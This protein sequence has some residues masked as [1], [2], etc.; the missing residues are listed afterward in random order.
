M[1]QPQEVLGVKIVVGLK[2]ASTLWAGASPTRWLVLRPEK[3]STTH[4]FRH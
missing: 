3:E 4:S 1:K 2:E